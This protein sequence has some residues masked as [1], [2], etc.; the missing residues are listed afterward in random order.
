[1]ALT[2]AGLPQYFMSSSPAY[3][4]IP[5]DESENHIVKPTPRFGTR[6]VLFLALA[7]CL[8]ALGSYKAGQW[9]IQKDHRLSGSPTSDQEIPSNPKESSDQT[10]AEPHVNSTDMPGKYSVG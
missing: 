5:T 1:V 4:P 2:T 6:K 7:F 10:V 3:Q 9:S 8:V